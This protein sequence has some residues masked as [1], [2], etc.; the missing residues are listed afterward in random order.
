MQSSHGSYMGYNGGY[1]CTKTG[2]ILQSPRTEAT[3]SEIVL[4]RGSHYRIVRFTLGTLYLDL[5]SDCFFPFRNHQKKRQRRISKGFLFL[6]KKSRKIMFEEVKRRV[7]VFLKNCQWK[8]GRC[9][10]V[11]LWKNPSPIGGKA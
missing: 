10:L 8:K 9:F 1:E 2:M 6:F 3:L 7:S 11:G 5:V 4:G